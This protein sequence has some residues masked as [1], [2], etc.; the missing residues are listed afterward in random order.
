[1]RVRVRVRV[2][3]GVRLGHRWARRRE[4]QGDTGRYM[5]MEI[6]GDTGRFLEKR[7]SGYHVPGIVVAGRASDCFHW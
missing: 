1:M 4:I 5:D 2:G 6:R 3:R 7:S